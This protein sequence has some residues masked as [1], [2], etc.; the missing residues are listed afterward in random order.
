MAAF[1]MV[2][3]GTK[4]AHWADGFAYQGQPT[5]PSKPAHSITSSVAEKH[6]GIVSP[7]A[8]A[9]VRLMTKSNLVG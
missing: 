1:D 9:V 3:H 5:E 4:P 6:S 8:L 2:P 7:R